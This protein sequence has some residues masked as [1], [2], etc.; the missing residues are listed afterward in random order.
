[1][2]PI[3]D[4]CFLEDGFRA[5]GEFLQGFGLIAES[6]VRHDYIA[7]CFEESESESERDSTATAGHQGGLAIKLVNGHLGIGS[8]YAG[9]KSQEYRYEIEKWRKGS[10][11][12]EE[13]GWARYFPIPP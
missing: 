11:R 4:I 13:R 1:M 12:G 9:M 8:S 7:A 5:A 6:E 3:G 2:G 10:G